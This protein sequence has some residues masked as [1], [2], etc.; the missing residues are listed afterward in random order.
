VALE[1]DQLEDA[2]LREETAKMLF[3]LLLHKQENRTHLWGW[4]AEKGTPGRKAGDS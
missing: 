2:Q 1:I 3:H 4:G